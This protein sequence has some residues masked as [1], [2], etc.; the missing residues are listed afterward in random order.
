[1]NR[2]VLPSLFQIDMAWGRSFLHGSE[3]GREKIF[4]SIEISRFGFGADGKDKFTDEILQ[5]PDGA[6][7]K[8]LR[9]K[10]RIPTDERLF[11]IRYGIKAGL[12]TEEINEL[13]GI[14]AWF[15]DNMRELVAEEEQVKRFRNE[16]NDTGIR[17]PVDILVR[18][19]KDGFSDRQLAYLLNQLRLH[20]YLGSLKLLR[21]L[22]VH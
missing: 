10:I 20:I 8:L 2:P 21:V 18:A 14:D 22:E 1:M 5:R 9:D 19:K 7:L 11:Y 13:S 6:L 17:L 16:H 15:I 3:N 4:R 12:S